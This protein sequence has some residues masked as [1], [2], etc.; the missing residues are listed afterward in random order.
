M[1]AGLYRPFLLMR[2]YYNIALDSH[3]CP[4]LLALSFRSSLAIKYLRI[5]FFLFPKIIVNSYLV[6]INL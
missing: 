2:V 3:T 5:I 6:V 1:Y 4:Q